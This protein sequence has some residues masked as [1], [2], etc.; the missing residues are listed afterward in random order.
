MLQ[1]LILFHPEPLQSVIERKYCTCRRHEHVKGGE[2]IGV[3]DKCWEWYHPQCVALTQ[4]ELEQDDWRC[5]YCVGE[6]KD[7]FQYW[8]SAKPNFGVKRAKDPP[9]RN[10]KM[11]PRAL[12]IPKE[13]ASSYKDGKAHWVDIVVEARAKGKII[14]LKE[15]A[16]KSMAKEVLKE[17]G[18]HVVDEMGLEGTQLRQVDDALVQDFVREGILHFQDDD[19]V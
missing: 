1:R 12:G 5:G 19:D 11:T 15:K 10:V 8:G 16:M 18:H 17:G 13:A 6:V 9:K 7:G 4:E 3:C 2:C 14:N